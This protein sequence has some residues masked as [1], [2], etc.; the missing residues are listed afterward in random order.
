M[1]INKAYKCRLEPTIEQ[2][3]ILNNLVGS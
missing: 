1:K 3:I 2:E